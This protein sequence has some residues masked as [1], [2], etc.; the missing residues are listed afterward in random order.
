VEGQEEKEKEKEEVT[1]N[2]KKVGKSGL[3]VLTAQI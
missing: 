1:N 3:C 2:K